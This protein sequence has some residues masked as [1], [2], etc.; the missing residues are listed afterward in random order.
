MEPWMTPADSSG[1]GDEYS[2]L[3]KLDS[4]FG[5]AT[6]QSLVQ[7]YRQ[8][9]TT[10]RDLDNIKAL[11]LNVVRV[12]VWWGDFYALTALGQDNP[13]MRSDAFT[14]LDWLVNA[15]ST[16]GIYTIIDMHGVFGGQ[17]T[18]A[19]TGM[20]NKNA[21]WA[22]KTAQ[23]ATGEMWKA[24]AA[25]YKGNAG[26]AGY[27]LLNEPMGAPNTQAVW[28]ALNTLYHDIRAAD[29]NHILF[30]E[31]TFGSW[32]WSMLPPPSKYGWTNVVYEMHEYQWSKQNPDGVQAGADNQ[33]ADAKAHKMWNVPPYV[34]EFNAFG[35]GTPA[36]KHVIGAFD[37]AGVNWTSWSYKATH[38]GGVDSWGLYNPNSG[39]HTVPNIESDTSSKISRDWAEWTTARAFA[40]NP[41]VEA[42]YSGSW[43]GG[44]VSGN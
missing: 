13:A 29:P 2:I 26:V 32:N 33:C 5:I 25:H 35:T 19:S 43:A 27:D 14:L 44:K 12:P 18:S 16:R 17:S 34:G 9:W 22:D 40:V 41:M 20:R 3:Q 36:W 11:G 8:S 42:A 31:G 30:M 10:L 21:Y 1:L 15:A 39:K 24:I 28:G 38:G 4:R 7:G 6:E 37:K 23:L